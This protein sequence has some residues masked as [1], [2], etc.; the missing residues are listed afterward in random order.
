MRGSLDTFFEITARW[1]LTQSERRVLLGSPT[2]ELW[3]HFIRDPQPR[4]TSQ[5]FSRVQAVVQ[6]EEALSNC[7]NIRTRQRAGCKRWRGS[8]PSLVAPRSPCC[9]V[10]WRISR[11]SQTISSHGDRT[12]ERQC[13]AE[14]ANCFRLRDT[15][16]ALTPV[17][18]GLR[19]RRR[20]C[21]PGLRHR[22]KRAISRSAH[23]SPLVDAGRRLT[24][25]AGEAQ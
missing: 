5:E 3:F 12:G 6:L 19:S 25:G 8:H 21:S 15:R 17:R 16:C 9:C 1:R 18:I 24:T 13:L 2:D 23:P 11:Q 20:A 4:I 7:V 22:L 14:T 10:A